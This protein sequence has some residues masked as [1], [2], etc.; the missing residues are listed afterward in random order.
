M[1]AIRYIYVVEMFIMINFRVLGDAIYHKLNAKGL[2]F[3]YM[4]QKKCQKYLYFEQI[5]FSY[6]L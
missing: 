5:W 2:L 1:Q 6:P 4:H 3:V